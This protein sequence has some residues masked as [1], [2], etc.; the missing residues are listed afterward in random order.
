MLVEKIDN[1]GLDRLWL[2]STGLLDRNGKEIYEGDIVQTET[3]TGVHVFCVR[4]DVSSASYMCPSVVD[5][6]CTTT[7]GQLPNSIEI[8]GNIYQNKDLLK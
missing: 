3:S 4:Y 8:I 1:N 6:E 2:Q 5:E 7:I